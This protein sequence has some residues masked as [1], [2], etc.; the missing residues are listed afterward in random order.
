MARMGRN[1]DLPPPERI[2]ELNPNHPTVAGIRGLFE[3]KPDDP[4]LEGYCRLLY[5]QAVI[6]EGSKLKDPLAFA[7]RINELLATDAGR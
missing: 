6:A 1:K 5:D 2:L 7:K 3:R 4:R